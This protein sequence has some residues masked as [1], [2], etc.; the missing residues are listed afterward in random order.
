MVF[1]ATQG[2]VG[3]HVPMVFD[4]FISGHGGMEMAGG[5]MAEV[6]YY[7]KDVPRQCFK[8]YCLDFHPGTAESL[9][10]RMVPLGLEYL[11]K[12]APANVVPTPQPKLKLVLTASEQAPQITSQE[13]QIINVT[14]TEAGTQNL[15]INVV[16]EI[17]ITMPDATKITNSLDPTDSNGRTSITIP[18]MPSLANS[19]MVVYQVCVK[20][21]ALAASCVNGSYLIW[22]NKP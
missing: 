15:A 13:K 4:Q 7:E 22:N 16:T 11:K 1:Y 8:N 3:Y 17:T 20:D 14:A 5:P 12:L 6:M 9:Q 18:A 21:S 2:D 10:V 19:S